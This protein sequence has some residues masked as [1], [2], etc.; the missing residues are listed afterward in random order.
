MELLLA[1]DSSTIT[2]PIEQLRRLNIEELLLPV[3]IQLIVIIVVARAFGVL[4]RW[5][6]QPTV[7]GEIV[8]GILMGPSVFGALFPAMSQMIF[9]PHLHGVDDVMTAAAF[10][11]IFAVLA[12][13]G[14]IFLLFLIGLEFEFSH[15][16]IKGRSALV[17][18]LVGVLLPFGLGAALA[19]FIHGILEPH[20]DTGKPVPLLG[21]SLFLGTAMSITA[22]PILGRM[23]VE[24]GINRTKLRRSSL[25]R[26]PSMMR[27]AGRCS[28]PS[29]RSFGRNFTLGPSS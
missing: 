23:M 29:R 17:I 1:S 26:R 9:K 28:R 2:N 8:A 11:K 15:L 4:F 3:L 25:P 10:P 19:P 14:L 7:V 5:L 27:P 20:Q 18:C 24:L 21:L 16:K 12:Q 13:L 22:L 6:N